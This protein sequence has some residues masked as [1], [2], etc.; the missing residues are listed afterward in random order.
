MLVSLNVQ[1]TPLRYTPPFG[2]PINF[3]VTYNERDSVQQPIQSYS[4]LGPKWTFGWL[5]YVIDQRNVALPTVTVYVPGGGAEIFRRDESGG[6]LAFA[7]FLPDPQSHAILTQTGIDSYEKQ[8]P[9]GT[10]QVFDHPSNPNNPTAFRRKV[11]MTEIR[12]PANNPVQIN[13]V[14]TRIAS[15]TDALGQQTDL[16]YELASDPFKITKVV[17]P[18]FGDPNHTRRHANF[19]YENGL[20]QTITD[21]IT[22]QSVFDYLPG[23]DIIWKITTPY[24]PTTFERG[25]NDST[26]GGQWIE[27]TD[28]ELAKERVEYQDNTPEIDATAPSNQVPAGMAV[29]NVNLNKR[30]TFYWSKEAIHQFPPG[31]NGYDYT[32]AK[33]IHWL[34]PATPTPI[35]SPTPTPTGSPTP[36]PTPRTSAIV[37]SEKMPLEYRVWYAYD[38]Q[39]DLNH[40]GT[41]ASPS[42]IARVV[43]DGTVQT[44]QVWLYEYLNNFQKMTKSTDPRGREMTYVYD[45]TNHIDLLEIRQTT[46][47]NNELIHEF[48]DYTD[49]RPRTEYDASRQLTSYNYNEFGQLLT[50]TRVRNGV[51]ETTTYTYG[52]GSL[53]PEWHL[54]SITS[55]PANG[56]SAVITFGYDVFHRIEKITNDPDDYTVYL[57]LD[58]LDRITNISY[59]DGTAENFVYKQNFGQGLTTI[60]DLTSSKDRL[61][62]ET[63]RHYNRNRQVDWVQD[64]DEKTTYFNRCP[65]GSLEAI[66]D[67]KGNQ[68]K[69]SRDLQGRVTHKTFA[70]DTWY[71]STIDYSYEDAIDRLSSVTDALIQTT[72]YKYWPDN[73][74]KQVAY[75]NAHHT[76]PTVDYEYDPNYN[77]IYRAINAISTI[78]YTYYP[79]TGSVTTGAGKLHTIGGVFQGDTITYVYDEFGRATSQSINQTVSS[80]TYDPLGRITTTTNPLTPSSNFVYSY[81]GA[82]PRLQSVIHPATGQR[83][84]YHYYN[85]TSDLR[86]ESIESLA[87]NNANLSRFDY[88]YHSDG[89]IKSLTKTLAEASPS[90]LWFGYDKVKRLETAHDQ[91]TLEDSTYAIDYTYD[92]AGNRVRDHLYQPVFQN[93][94]VAHEFTTNPLNQ[95]DSEVTTV[96]GVPS[97]PVALSYDVNGNLLNDGAG[98]T[99]EWDAANR[100]SAINYSQTGARTEFAYDALGRRV[101]ITETGPGVTAVIQPKSNDYSEYT[102]APFTLPAGNYTLK[103]EGLEKSAMAVALVD[104]VR[105]NTTV[106]PNGSFEDPDVSQEPGGYQYNP[107]GTG[108]TYNY[109]SGIA[110]NGSDLTS[111]NPPAPDAN[112]V[113]FLQNDGVISQVWAASGGTYTLK[114][115][116]AQ[117]KGVNEIDQRFQVTLRPSVNAVKV[118]T[119]VWCGARICEERD[120]NGANVVKRFFAEGEQW[121]SGGEL[122]YYTRDHLGSIREVTNSGGAIQ[123]QYDYDP[124]GNRVV[125]AGKIDTDFGYTGHY[126]HGQS[127]LNL[128]LFRAY[129]PRL[130][131]WISRDPIGESVGTNLYR[132]SRNNPF[133]WIDPLGLAEIYT[134]MTNGRTYLNPNPESPGPIRSWESSNNIVVGALPGADG[135]YESLDVYPARGPWHNLPE[136]FGPNDILLTDDGRGRWL[137]GGGSELDDPLAPRQGWWPTRGCTRFQNEDIQDLVNRVRQLKREHPGLKIPYTRSRPPV[138]D[139]PV[140]FP[141]RVIG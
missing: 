109:H 106:V 137:H 15:I 28:P 93:P 69:F 10:I 85:L 48:A 43:F 107:S 58:E 46:G 7:C 65:C 2:L 131:R 32:K 29:A 40:E 114:F 105:L 132:Y 120:S 24:G 68:T 55:P 122:Y 37:A 98:K 64:S 23:T 78:T 126:Y 60:L 70:Y 53:A 87:G 22:I 16:L 91:E 54:Q 38:G 17:E 115:K 50:S 52:D 138:G 102:T 133:G 90:P 13:Y 8:L 59:P 104:F 49:H 35:G 127:A 101:K 117:S 4:N 84:E 61:N 88:T 9:D 34:L 125:V 79:I 56:S 67:P 14:G 57:T 3:T 118:K 72:T 116:A 47:T 30:N 66:I 12:D 80:V 141:G 6:C 99:Y 129:S 123:A 5:S 140:L 128:T 75:L 121:V 86:L 27:A 100:L 62:R 134:D 111:N 112:Q 139:F 71:S 135:P 25:L 130:G 41:N 73:N 1:D 95:L 19:V 103:F 83:T 74:L 76:T 36:T 26:R 39:S 81:D 82:T 42:K 20:L 136:S 77:R 96:N 33:T 89:Q 113:A 110:A 11:F 63:L 92:S 119:F 21:E 94:G 124:Y 44:D 18:T 51:P 97:P 45:T 31:S 108:W